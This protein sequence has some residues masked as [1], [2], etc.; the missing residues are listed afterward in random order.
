MYSARSYKY[1]SSWGR[2]LSPGLDLYK[3]N[4]KEKYQTTTIQLEKEDALGDSRPVKVH[5]LVAYTFLGNPVNKSDTVDHIDRNTHNNRLSNLR[6]ASVNVQLE[7]REYARYQLQTEDGMIHNSVTEAA[8]V[9]EIPINTLMK[10]VQLTKSQADEGVIEANGVKLNNKVV[11]RKRKKRDPNANE[12][13]KYGGQGN[14]KRK[15]DCV[16]ELF[17]KGMSIDDICAQWEPK[18]L[19][20]KTAVKYFADSVKT[21][22]REQ[23]R[24]IANCF[25]LDNN[26]IDAMHQEMSATTKRLTAQ[27]DDLKRHIDDVYGPEDSRTEKQKEEVSALY[28]SKLQYDAAYK[29]VVTHYLP[30]IGDNWDLVRW[31]NWIL[32]NGL[33]EKIKPIEVNDQN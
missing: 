7:N 23:L 30:D 26:T 3:C 9:H 32:Y 1:I 31:T 14:E 19:Q 2:L 12:P 13:D 29:K 16:L 17:M 18:A 28:K 20:R 8:R 4:N 11:S 6:W 10:R 24:H 25:H 27:K 22:N 21:L 33:V 5:V 15:Q